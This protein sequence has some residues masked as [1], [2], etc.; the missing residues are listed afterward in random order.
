MI[1]LNEHGFTPS[2]PPCWLRGRDWGRTAAGAGVRLGGGGRRGRGTG[3]FGLRRLALLLPFSFAVRA[4]VGAVGAALLMVG[5]CAIVIQRRRSHFY[6]IQVSR[7]VLL[8]V[9]R[10]IPPT[11]A[12]TRKGGYLCK[13]C[14][15][16]KFEKLRWVVGSSP[17]RGQFRNLSKISND[18]SY[19]SNRLS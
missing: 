10:D 8:H 13:K 18:T 11:T 4:A 1:H 7:K 17:R 3:S 19:P 9:F 14:R 12:T 2:P 15:C 6:G 16:R 5:E